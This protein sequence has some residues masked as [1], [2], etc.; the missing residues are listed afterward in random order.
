MVHSQATPASLSARWSA[1]SPFVAIFWAWKWPETQRLKEFVFRG[2]S[3]IGSQAAP[4][5]SS[6]TAPWLRPAELVEFM[7]TG[8]P[9]VDN[10]TSDIGAA[11]VCFKTDNLDGLYH[12][13]V[14]HGVRMHYPPQHVGFGSVTYFRDPDGIILEAAQDD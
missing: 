5:P 1:R 7:P 14:S 10:K 13:L 9:L 6:G 12:K 2:R 8:K 3:A 4:G 11:H